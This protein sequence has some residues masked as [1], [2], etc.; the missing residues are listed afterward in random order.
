MAMNMKNLDFKTAGF[1]PEKA[2]MISYAFTFFAVVLLGWFL[3]IS[4]KRTQLKMLEE[5]EAQLRDE[6]STLQIKA[7]SLTRLKQELAQINDLLV[8][9]IGQLP[10]KN[11]IPTLVV[12]VSQAAIAN[13]LQ[14]D[15]FKPQDEVKKDFYAEKRID[16][17][18]KGDYHQLGAFF[19]DVAMQPRLI[20]V[21]V[22]GMK[23]TV[24]P[25]EKQS[26][27][28]TLALSE[29]AKSEPV[30]DFSGTVRTYRYLSADEESEIAKE[31]AELEKKNK[32]KNAK[33]KAKT[34]ETAEAK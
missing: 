2:K 27:K 5:T 31:K 22:E 17:N 11:E 26:K 8:S 4:G 16:V 3:A 12:N 20:S 13:G 24:A 15:L 32:K 23:M 6:Y 21:V 33:S 34:E 7:N 25:E 30:L 1:W 19:S 29:V 18:F 14:V 28:T 10:N 9:L